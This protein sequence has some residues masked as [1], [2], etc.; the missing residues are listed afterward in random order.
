MCFI[1]HRILKRKRPLTRKSA[2]EQPSKSEFQVG[3]SGKICIA[4]IRWRI[5]RFHHS[6]MEVDIVNNYFYPLN[7]S[8][9]QHVLGAYSS[10]LSW[11]ALSPG[12]S[13]AV[14]ICDNTCM[15]RTTTLAKPTLLDWKSVILTQKFRLQ[16]CSETHN[17][18]CDYHK[19]KRFSCSALQNKIRL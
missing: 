1:V 19:P 7:R 15:Q 12:K 16:T 14:D 6:S 17:K 11:S 5:Q 2:M 3:D 13:A 8:L 4:W 9:W 10:C 18:V